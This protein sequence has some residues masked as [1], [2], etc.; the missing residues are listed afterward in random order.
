MHASCASK[1]GRYLNIVEEQTTDRASVDSILLLHFCEMLLLNNMPT[2]EELARK[3]YKTLSAAE[4]P[5]NGG[6]GAL[7]L[8]FKSVEQICKL[9]DLASRRKSSILW[10]GCGDGRE[11]LAVATLFPLCHIDAVDINEDCIALCKAKLKKLKEQEQQKFRV[12]FATKDAMDIDLATVEKYHC[13]YSTAVVNHAF[14]TQLVNFAVASK[15]R[16]VRLCM[17]RDMWSGINLTQAS[18]FE[19]SLSVNLQG[20]GARKTLRVYVVE[21]PGARRR[22]QYLT[23]PFDEDDGHCKVKCRVRRCKG[24]SRRRLKR[25]CSCVRASEYCRHHDD[26]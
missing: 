4:C 26:S 21:G 25:C 16:G 18:S 5:G 15:R 17:F 6:G 1:S 23:L 10:I 11:V 12:T 14:Y 22:L 24:M 9:L 19:N 8:T 3:A 20:S 2:R 7:A 13:I